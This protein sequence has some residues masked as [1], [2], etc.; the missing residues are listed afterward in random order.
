MFGRLRATAS[1]ILGFGVATIGL[2]NVMPA[3]GSFR[4]GPFPIEEFRAGFFALCI[5]VVALTPDPV[6]R[7]DRLRGTTWRYWVAA[8]AA[9]V[10][11]YTCWSYYSIGMVLE[12]SIVLFGPRDAAVALVAVAVPLYFCWRFW[13]L[14]V[15][16]LGVIAVAYLATGPYWPGFLR[17]A[18]TGVW[19]TLAQNL[20]YST[21]AGVLGTIFGIVTT[22]V[23]PF[24]ILGAVLEGVG[25][26]ES[27][28]R[29]S[30]SLM[31][32]T[33][34]GPAHAAVLASG[35]FGTV[36]GSAVANVVGTGVVTIP[37][38]KRR[39]FSANFAGAVEAAASTG[40][41]IMPPIMGAAAIVMADYVG[42]TYLTVIVAVLLPALAYYLSLFVMI[43]FESRR[44]GLRADAAAATEQAPD[45]QDWLNLVMVFAPLVLI[46]VLLA[47][48]MSPAGASIAATFL[49]IPLS[50][51]NPAV[52]RQPARLLTSLRDGGSTFAQLAMAIAAVGVVIATLSA[53][54][55]PVKFGVLLANASSHALLPA[56]AL[57][58]LGCIVL[59]MGMPTLPAYVTVVV[60]MAPTMESLGLSALT[61]HMFVFF[62]AVASAITPPVAIA[63]YAGASIARGRPIA[64]ATIA[65]RI[66]IMIFIIPFAFAYNP[67]ILTVHEAGASFSWPAYL[68]LVAKLALGIYV[69]GSALTRFDRRRLS[70]L[71]AGL[72]VVAAVLLF[73]PGARTD[74]LGAG[75]SLA[76]LLWHHGRRWPAATVA[77]SSS[78]STT[79]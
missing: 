1:W 49:L 29:I 22:T 67:L 71:E 23:L 72:R 43:M 78:K 36:S 55:I 20:W 56:L 66:G 11:V 5:A 13:G 37:M 14:P 3:V 59:G 73:A 75:L 24:I 53:T 64:T 32:R 48:G 4:L 15:A 34:G 46:V 60:M 17:T 26:G 70:W 77:T 69:L 65:T 61:A 40:G 19:E 30:F 44:M 21:D 35:L 51:I 18:P 7:A 58:A 68:L 16:L 33:A 76:L 52:R 62:I 47:R 54:G 9:L 2:A 38:I 39:G 27:M 79:P 74:W 42:V 6:E 8:L 10:G 50:F 45:R 63:A 41:Q 28:I 25:A 12:E 31:R 57:A